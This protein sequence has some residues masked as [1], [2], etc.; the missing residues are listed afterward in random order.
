MN[1]KITYYAFFII[2]L[3][4]FFTKASAQGANSTQFKSKFSVA[5]LQ[6]APVKLVPYPQSVDWHKGTV[7][8]KSI[9][10]ASGNAL[11]RLI[12][13]ELYQV[14]NEAGIELNP[15]ADYFI[16]FQKKEMASEEGYELN[17]SDKGIQVK[18][19]TD[20]G[21]YYGLQTLRQ[22]LRTGDQGSTISLC[23]IVDAPAH[24]IR[25][26][27]IDVGRNYQSMSSLKAQLDLMARYKLN[28]FHWHLTDR[29]A[30]RIESKK[31]PQ[32]TA[33]ENHRATRNPG[34][35]YSYDEIR[36]LMAYARKR[37]ITVIP[38]IDMPGHSDS[39]TKAMGFKM[40][41]PEGM[42][43]LEEILKEFFREIPKEL[44]P[45][46][47]IGSDEVHIPNPEEFIS[48]MTHI[49]EGHDREVVIWNPGLE[50]KSSVIRQVW[51]SAKPSSTRTGVREID[52]RNSYINGGEP[53]TF[54][55]TLFFK[56]IG[57]EQGNEVLG[58][59]LCLWPDVNLIKEEDAFLQNP[60]Y[61][62]LLTYAWSTWTA[63][64]RSASQ[65]YWMALPPKESEAARYFA[66]FETYLVAHKQRYFSN[67]P[68]QY[69]G[70]SDKEWQ[71]IGP[72]DGDEGD[73]FVR[74]IKP[75]YTYQGQLFQWK[76]ARGNTLA[77]KDRYKL[78]GYYPEAKA[79]QTVYA[80][81]YIH[82]DQNKD[83]EVWL[84]FETPL[85][86]NRIYTGIAHNGEWDIN[87]GEVWVND[88]KLEGPVWNNPGW[89]T[90]KQEGWGIP[91][92]QEIPWAKEELYWT[93]KPAKIALK[94]DWN[95]VFVKIPAS[96][97]YQNWMFTFAPLDMKG[98]RFSVKP[99][100]K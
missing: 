91:G 63:D 96:T 31:Y 89:K 72:F 27:M 95:K 60:V 4:G 13:D 73:D 18:A 12:T 20:T 3:S 53:M 61:P 1:V 11:S 41:S 37:M 2:T 5:E 88:K 57:S 71:L 66:A 54:I 51:G 36:E 40:E 17:V 47:H 99:A 65:T 28:V 50:A 64:V 33:A 9:R 22:L 85:R 49:V 8:V 29:P 45:I 38:E 83:I 98:L 90:Q 58:G 93:R 30:W 39:F 21:F 74:K 46:I 76:Q 77:I 34:K 87:G 78:G 52:S 35:F 86:A 26:Y 15:E 97:G 81:T 7:L 55:N 32:L 100:Q 84:N 44:A 59:I 43:A 69:L 19:S 24:V 48:K 62:A 79:G 80:L 68:F 42:H 25:G 94:K 56:P 67:K 70:Q 75:E 10:V 23:E 14:S 92:D 82:S 6:N 16:R